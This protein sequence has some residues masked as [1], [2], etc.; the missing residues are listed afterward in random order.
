MTQIREDLLQKLEQIAESQHRDVNDVLS[1]LLAPLTISEEETPPP[2]TLAALAASARRANIQGEA[3]FTSVNSREILNTEY[4]EY[5][6]QRLR[7]SHDDS[8]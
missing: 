7:D 5:L 3:R 6:Q 1:D 2:G 8:H 4:A